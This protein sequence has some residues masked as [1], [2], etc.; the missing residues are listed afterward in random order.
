MLGLLDDLLLVPAGI[1]LALKLIP[2]PLMDELRAEAETH[3]ARPVS[4]RAALIVVTI[5]ITVAAALAYLWLRP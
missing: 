4:K 5:W 3:A 2:A 1:W